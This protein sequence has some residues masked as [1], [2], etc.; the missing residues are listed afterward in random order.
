MHCSSKK[1]AQLTLQIQFDADDY[2]TFYLLHL[3]IS[4][5]IKTGNY[6]I[7]D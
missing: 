2:E 1:D 7:L 6:V 3:T 5:I 4:E